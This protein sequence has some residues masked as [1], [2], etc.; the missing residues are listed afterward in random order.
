MKSRSRCLLVAL[1]LMLPI[2]ASLELRTAFTSEVVL[3]RL[4]L[5]TAVLNLPG[6]VLVYGLAYE[7]DVPMLSVIAAGDAMFWVPTIYAVLR[8]G[9]WLRERRRRMLVRGERRTR[10]DAA[11]A[12]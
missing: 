11:G 2:V 4:G 1:W 9:E 3:S 12:P 10:M 6:F 7:R 8:W 5:V